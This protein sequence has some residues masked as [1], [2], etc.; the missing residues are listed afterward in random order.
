MKLAATLAQLVKHWT[1]V[2]QAAGSNTG[3]PNQYY[4]DRRK[5]SHSNDNLTLNAQSCCITPLSCWDLNITY[6]PRIILCS[7]FYYFNNS[8]MCKFSLKKMKFRYH[9]ILYFTCYWIDVIVLQVI[10]SFDC[11][12]Y[13][14]KRFIYLSIY[15]NWCVACQQIRTNIKIKKYEGRQQVI[16]WIWLWLI[17]RMK[18]SILINNNRHHSWQMTQSVL[19]YLPYKRELNLCKAFTPKDSSFE[20]WK[21]KT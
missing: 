5:S 11:D 17:S 21:Y 13:F 19:L 14:N 12:L 16:L 8:Q 7:H 15:L 6:S 18:S 1:M 20:L 2:R 10:K 4:N 3:R 9:T